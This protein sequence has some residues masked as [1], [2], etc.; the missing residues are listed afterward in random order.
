MNHQLVKNDFLAI[1]IKTKDKNNYYDIL[2]ECG[3]NNNLN[4]FIN[5]I[6]ELEEEEL[7]FY[8]NVIK[9]RKNTDL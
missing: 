8:L 1:S 3:I 6:C 4:L 2:E 9:L 5:M 7:D